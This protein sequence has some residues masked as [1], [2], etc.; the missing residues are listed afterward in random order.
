M[1]RESWYPVAE[2][3]ILA[4]PVPNLASATFPSVSYNY[5]P[6]KA[7]LLGLTREAR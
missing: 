6:S 4:M 5:F 3:E 2:D 1:V 7:S